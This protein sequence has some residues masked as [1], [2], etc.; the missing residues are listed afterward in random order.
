LHK[1][2]GVWVISLL[3]IRPHLNERTIWRRWIVTC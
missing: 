3:P 1:C 2:A